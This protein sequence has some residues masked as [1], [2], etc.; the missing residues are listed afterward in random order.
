MKR[1]N[2]KYLGLLLASIMLVLQTA[3][4][5]VI[6]EE[7]SY[8]ESKQEPDKRVEVQ[9]DLPIEGNSYYDLENV[10]LYLYLYEELPDNYMTKTEARELGWEGG[11][12]EKYKEGAAIGGD[13]FGNREGLLP[14]EKGRTYTECDIDTDGE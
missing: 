7:P 11:S 2:K 13:T 1:R 6:L 3:C 12:V 4:S 14:K 10:V 9:S 8:Y 5:I